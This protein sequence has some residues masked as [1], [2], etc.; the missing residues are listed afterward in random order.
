MIS[1]GKQT[2]E[3]DDIEAI[4]SVLRSDWLTQCPSVQDFE[5]TC[6]IIL[7]QT[8]HAPFQTVQQ[9]CI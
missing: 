2:I 5:M 1:Y 6:A 8:L 3:N 7:E 4:I 9:P